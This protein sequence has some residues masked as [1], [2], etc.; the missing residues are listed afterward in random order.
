M[1]FFSSW[2]W[3]NYVT[4]A[5][6]ILTRKRPYI[7]KRLIMMIYRY[8]EDPMARFRTDQ[9]RWWRRDRF[10]YPR[11]SWLGSNP[12]APLQWDE[13]W[14]LVGCTTPLP[15]YSYNMQ[16]DINCLSIIN[17]CS[18]LLSSCFLT[19]WSY[20]SWS[21]LISK[22]VKNMYMKREKTSASLKITT[23]I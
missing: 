11:L 13:T 8:L 1:T 16:E 18:L 6:L 12:P 5:M 20:G 19:I 21:I 7:F 10:L 4:W 3:G 17:G 9:R 22:Q 14:T 23:N 15:F 2:N